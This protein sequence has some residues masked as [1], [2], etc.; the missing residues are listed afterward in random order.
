MFFMNEESFR[1]DVPKIPRQEKLLS[2]VPKLQLGNPR[3]P[4]APALQQAEAGALQR[5]CVAKVD[6]EKNVTWTDEKD[7]MEAKKYHLEEKNVTWAEKMSLEPKKLAENDAAWLG[8]LG[9]KWKT[10]EGRG[11]S[12]GRSAGRR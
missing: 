7:H 1:P 8:K 6:E 11:L 10:N 3:Q 5:F 9:P 4:K 2:L 12:T